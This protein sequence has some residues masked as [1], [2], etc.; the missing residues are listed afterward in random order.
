MFG[1]RYTD[2]RP[3][4]SSGPPAAADVSDG[5]KS[6]FGQLVE[7]YLS[8]E[9]LLARLKTLNVDL[10][11]ARDYRE[12]PG[13]NLRLAEARLTQVRDRRSAVLA[14]LRANR[15]LARLLLTHTGGPVAA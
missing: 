4:S 12:A 11:R 8:N 7:L 15:S 6:L 1:P 5:E 10:R 9:S 2:G 3:F 13:S 14:A